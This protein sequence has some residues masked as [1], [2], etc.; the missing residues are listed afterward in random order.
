MARK[1]VAA[2]SIVPAQNPGALPPPP[3]SLS[4]AESVLWREIVESKP[5]DWFGPDTLPILA[6]YV[7]AVVMCDILAE[8]VGKALELGA[9]VAKQYLDMRD[10]ESRRAVSL[11]TK[12]RLTQQSKYG[13][14]GAERAD[15]TASGKRPWQ[16]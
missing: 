7:R 16:A 2:L 3:A 10:K 4:A 15:R 14:R 11:A 13:A 12:M 8:R 1:S 6:E 5:S 9:D